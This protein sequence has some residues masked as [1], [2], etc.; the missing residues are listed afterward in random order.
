MKRIVAVWLWLA[1]SIPVLAGEPS[2]MPLDLPTAEQLA[3]EHNPAYLALLQTRQIEEGHL[4]Q[5]GLYPNPSLQAETADLPSNQS[6]AGEIGLWYQQ[7]VILSGRLEKSQ[8]MA[9][10]G[11][12]LAL[13]EIAWRRLQLL[14][15]VRLAYYRTLVAQA[16]LARNEAQLALNRQIEQVLQAQVTAGKL[17]LTELNRARLV[18]GQLELEIVQTRQMAQQT[19]LQLASHWG[20]TAP[21]FSQVAGS[22]ESPL[23]PLPALAQ[24][25]AWLEQHPQLARWQSELAQRQASVTLERLK[26]WPDWQLSIGARYMP[27]QQGLG[28][29]T[30]VQFPLPLSDLN[31]GQI[32]AA[33]ATL[34]QGRIEAQAARLQLQTQLQQQLLAYQQSVQILDQLHKVMLPVAMDNLNLARI[35]WEAGKL[36]Y[37]GLLDAQKT[38]IALQQQEV[39]AWDSFYQTRTELEYLASQPL[40]ATEAWGQ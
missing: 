8:D 40:G 32:Q 6:T 18:T 12:N 23:L 37:L 19:R 29:L 25:L 5:A 28:V 2:S 1:L 13:A 30:Q 26:A 27:A 35:T 21:A 22:L 14:R 9:R 33:E 15:D 39:Q 24:W 38:L 36:P 31:Q 3:L 4:R 34:T 10:Q 11:L 7:P 20:E 16:S 17:L